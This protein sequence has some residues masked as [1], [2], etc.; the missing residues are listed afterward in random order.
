MRVYVSIRFTLVGPIFFD[1]AKA[2]DT[3]DHSILLIQLNNCGMRGVPPLWFK[4]Y[5]DQI[6]QFIAC[7]K[8]CQ[9]E[10]T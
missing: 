8:S 2:F 3:V 6:R 9:S 1:L 4:S 10:I 5:F 7:Y